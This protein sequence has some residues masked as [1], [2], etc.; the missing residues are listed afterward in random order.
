FRVAPCH[1]SL[2]A[3]VILPVTAEAATVA[4]LPRYSFASFAP[5]RPA[6]LLVAVE[7]ETSPE[8]T[9]PITA[10]L[11]GPQPGGSITAPASM[12]VPSRPSAASRR[13][14]ASEPGATN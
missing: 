5:K 8:C 12:K 11:Q 2:R 10:S 4:G 9:G 7:I 6:L 14:V 13:L 1:A 3:S